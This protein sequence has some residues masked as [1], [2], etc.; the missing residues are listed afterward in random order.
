M[1]NQELTVDVA[2]ARAAGVSDGVIQEVVKHHQTLR[3]GAVASIARELGPI[4]P[5]AAATEFYRVHRGE[6]DEGAEVEWPERYKPDDNAG[7]EAVAIAR[8]RY[9]HANAAAEAVVIYPLRRPGAPELPPAAAA[10]TS[11]NI[12]GTSPI[13]GGR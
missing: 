10:M 6:M 13:G 9:P 4:F 5:H 2:A 3:P 1:R 8:E 7:D 11:S 12:P